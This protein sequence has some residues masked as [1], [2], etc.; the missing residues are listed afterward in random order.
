MYSCR[1]RR[2]RHVVVGSDLL[3]GRPRPAHTVGL[4]IGISKPESSL[5][6]LN[7]SYQQVL[8]QPE[9]IN[10]LEECIQCQSLSTI[11][12]Q[13]AIRDLCQSFDYGCVLSQV[14]LR[15]SPKS[16]ELHVSISS[17]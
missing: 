8:L 2:R 9:V 13:V 5:Q 10:R 11:S 7:L 6:C 16:L 1:R 14:S 15:I 17:G 4:E 12:R 3:H